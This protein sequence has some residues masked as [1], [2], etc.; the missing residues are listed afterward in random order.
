MGQVTV[1]RNRGPEKLSSLATN[2]QQPS[3]RAGAHLVGLASMGW[4]G[5]AWALGGTSGGLV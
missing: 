3:V 5:Q 2:T 4:W 1:S